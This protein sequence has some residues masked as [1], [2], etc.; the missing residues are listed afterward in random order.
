M[1]NPVIYW[2]VPDN[3]IIDR[4]SCQWVQED[5]NIAGKPPDVCHHNLKNLANSAADKI[6]R[7]QPID[8]FIVCEEN[9]TR[10]LE[11]ADIVAAHQHYNL[12]RQL[13]PID[14][15]TENGTTEPNTPS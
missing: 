14:L 1:G 13:P 7:S 10:P 2:P 11:L 15:S 12:N 4:P 9:G 6:I 3:L 8:A 5:S